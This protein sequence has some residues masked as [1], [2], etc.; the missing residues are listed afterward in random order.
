VDD[1]L[2]S[3]FCASLYPTRQ[4][5]SDKVIA[6]ADR[7]IAERFLLPQERDEI[8]AEAEAAA[9]AFPECVPAR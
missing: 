8:I 4:A 2:G 1:A 7:L 6:A 5:Y 9:D 3:S